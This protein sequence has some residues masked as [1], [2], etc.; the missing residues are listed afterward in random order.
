[1]ARFPGRAHLG[2][3]S[4]IF[5]FVIVMGYWL[6]Q[7]V[8][9][10]KAALFIEADPEATVYVNGVEKGKTPLELE[11]EEQEVVLQMVASGASP[12]FATRVALTEGVKTIVRRRFGESELLG[13]SQTISF[14]KITSNE[15]EIA[16]VSIPDGAEVFLDGQRQGPTPLNLAPAAGEHTLRLIS[17][18]YKE[19][20][21]EIVTIPVLQTT[22][23]VDLAAKP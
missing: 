23:I 18:G 10:G 15:P 21:F 8:S 6:Y 13:S 17:A 2:G 1:M 3:V 14:E 9:F 5:A 20:E 12:P 7:T 22:V 4:V 16:I 19:E 11:I